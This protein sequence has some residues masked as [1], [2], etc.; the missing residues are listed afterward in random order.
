MDDGIGREAAK[1][2]RQEGHT[3]HA[4]NIINE[5]IA[6][7]T[8]N[9]KQNFIEIEDLK[10]VKGEPTGTKVSILIPSK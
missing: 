3:S 2:F 8:R 1:Q 6:A 9:N 7:L 4:L 10:S 5:R